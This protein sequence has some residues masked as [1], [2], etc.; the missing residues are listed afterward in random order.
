[1]LPFAAE[2]S[3]LQIWLGLFAL[4]FAVERLAHQWRERVE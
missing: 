4:A 1:M 3:S 2:P